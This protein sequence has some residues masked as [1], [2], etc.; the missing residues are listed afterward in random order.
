[1]GTQG[2]DGLHDMSVC[3]Y[4]PYPTPS[5]GKGYNK[6]YQ[7]SPWSNSSWLT[8]LLILQKTI[9]W[10]LAITVCITFHYMYENHLGIAANRVNADVEVVW[11]SQTEDMD[12]HVTRPVNL[13]TRYRPGFNM[14][15]VSSRIDL[16]SKAHN[17]LPR[18]SDMPFIAQLWAALYRYTIQSILDLNRYLEEGTISSKELAF[19]RMCDLV[20]SEVRI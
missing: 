15:M 10:S 8:V 7:Y 13:A 16:I 6:Y 5:D 17:V 18:H 19:R 2:Q 1:M 9:S 4:L 11:P 12:R 20:S 3:H 14:A